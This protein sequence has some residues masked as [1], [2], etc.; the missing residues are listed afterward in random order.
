MGRHCGNPD[1]WWFSMLNASDFANRT[2]KKGKYIL[3][4]YYGFEGEG[5][6]KRWSN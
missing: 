2:K 3:K 4:D 1:P 6:D 5:M